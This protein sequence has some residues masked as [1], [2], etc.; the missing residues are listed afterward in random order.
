MTANHQMLAL[1]GSIGNAEMLMIG[2]VA[3]LLFGNRLPEV[4]RSMGK[5]I[6]QFK[7]ALK[8]TQEEIETASRMP[9]PPTDDANNQVKAL[10]GGSASQDATTSM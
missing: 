3:L 1:F 2:L 10:P 9:T 6:V 5:G 8:D 4:M 7:R